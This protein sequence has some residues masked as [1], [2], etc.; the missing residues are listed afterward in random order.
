MQSEGAQREG[1]RIRAAM[2]QM[3]DEAVSGEETLAMSTAAALA[4]VATAPRIGQ[5]GNN[6]CANLL[7]IERVLFARVI[8]HSK[9]LARG[10]IFHADGA[11]FPH[12]IVV[13]LI[14]G[15]KRW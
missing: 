3:I 12:F 13:K 8:Q 1:T 10:E 15:E 14:V 4:E 7:E 11:T 6:Q 9:I 5:R 2:T